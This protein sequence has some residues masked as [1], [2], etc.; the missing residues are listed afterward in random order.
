MQKIERSNSLF[1]LATSNTLLVNIWTQQLGLFKGSQLAILEIVLELNLK[2]FRSEQPKEIIFVIRDFEKDREN[3]KN[4]SDTIYKKVESVWENILK[5]PG[6]ENIK[7]DDL[8]HLNTFFLPSFIEEKEE[9]R[10]ELSK[11]RD[12]LFTLAKNRELTKNNVLV[13]DFPKFLSNVW[14]TIQE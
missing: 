3:E 1:A 6:T 12:F 5:P 14:R 9:F 10:A 11:V 13:E 8:F 7:L 2:L 4:L